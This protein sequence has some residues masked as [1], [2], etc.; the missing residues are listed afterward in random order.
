MILKRINKAAA[1]QK[2]IKCGLSRASLDPA[3]GKL[4]VRGWFLGPGPL[5]I[6]VYLQGGDFLG[7]GQTHLPRP[8]ID[9]L[10]PEW[11][12]PDSGWQYQARL[13]PIST[14]PLHLQFHFFTNGSRVKKMTAVVD[15]TPG[16]LTVNGL[17]EEKNQPGAPNF[18]EQ[19]F[20]VQEANLFNK[21]LFGLAPLT[22]EDMDQVLKSDDYFATGLYAQHP[23]FLELLEKHYRMPVGVVKILC[24]Y[25]QRNWVASI[26]HRTAPGQVLSIRGQLLLRLETYKR[27]RE[28]LQQLISLFDIPTR[29]LF[30]VGCQFG[31]LLL[32]AAQEGFGKIAGAEINQ[33]LAGFV[34]ELKKYIE[35][36]YNTDYAYYFGDF[37]RL[38]FEPRGFNLVTCVD[39]LEHT[40]DLPKTMENMQ[41]ICSPGGMIYIY[42]GNGRSLMI[43]TSEPHYQLPCI[44]IL[45]IELAIEVM[46]HLGNITDKTR[47][48]VNQWPTL[49]EIHRSLIREDTCFEV[50]NTDVN[51]RN[52]LKYPE[53]RQLGMYIAKFQHTAEEKLLPRLT[54]FLKKEVRRYMNKYLEEIE[55]DKKTM[56]EIDFKKKYLMHSWNIILRPV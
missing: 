10:Y 13:A 16:E 1:R 38:E 22:D 3:T 41:K 19:N 18:Q 53:C 47:Y 42:Q 2:Q 17:P 43:A 45:P 28:A 26:K 44:S 24:D 21:L 40:P 6:K 37:T 46:T 9:R 48:L 8:D 36:H 35:E 55:K 11:G 50:Y 31:F 39:V 56:K 52:N 20:A 27:N 51:I 7:E 12:L 15:I 54:D 23:H 30:D 33:G 25:E 49:S 14:S 5:K 32:A 4:L 29:A 34:S